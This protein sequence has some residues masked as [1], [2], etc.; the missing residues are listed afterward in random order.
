M[1]SNYLKGSDI[2]EKIAEKFSCGASSN[3]T[4]SPNA[5]MAS[6]AP[7]SRCY[8]MTASANFRFACAIGGGIHQRNSQGYLS[9]CPLENI[10][11]VMFQ[12]PKKFYVKDDH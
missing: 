11:H 3:I 8:S 4:E 2:F 1:I 10:N 5:T 9:T 6:K 12:G 7:K